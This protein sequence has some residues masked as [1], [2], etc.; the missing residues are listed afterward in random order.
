MTHGDLQSCKQWRSDT[1]RPHMDPVETFYLRFTERVT[2]LDRRQPYPLALAATFFQNLGAYLKDQLTADGY[3][4]PTAATNNTDQLAQLLE[5]KTR[6]IQA[7]H[8]LNLTIKLSNRG[9]RITSRTN[10]MVASVPPIGMVSDASVSSAASAAGPMRPPDVY[11]R[12]L[13]VFLSSAEEALRNAI[14]PRQQL[15]C[16][17]CQDL[18]PQDCSHRYAD[19]PRRDDPE[20]RRA[21]IPH[22]RRFRERWQQRR[23]TSAN[24]ATIDLQ[25]CVDKWEEK[26]FP[27]KKWAQHLV[28]LAHPDTCPTVRRAQYQALVHK[29]RHNRSRPRTRLQW[30]QQVP[31]VPQ[32]YPPV[33]QASPHMGQLQHPGPIQP[34]GPPSTLV[35]P[36]QPSDQTSVI[37]TNTT[38]QQG[39]GNIYSLI[40]YAFASTV[41]LRLPP[42]L[43]VSELL[44]HIDIPMG[45]NT[46]VFH[47]RTLFD[48]GA[49]LNMGRLPYHKSIHERFPDV[50]LAYTDFEKDGYDAL[51]I[52]GIEGGDF[53]PDVRACITYNTPFITLGQRVTITFGLSD[54][55][56][57]NSILGIATQTK[58]RMTFMPAEGVVTSPTLNATFKVFMEQTKSSDSLPLHVL[59]PGQTQAFV[60]SP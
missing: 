29:I 17:G 4:V 34:P 3:I 21:A 52:G 19:C 55:C 27:N 20:V 44:P 45:M 36:Q 49:G 58:A 28:T 40:V 48:T 10:A 51:R 6:A 8:R 38:Q 42:Q 26:G 11:Q 16:F 43:A 57:S 25:E 30:Q 9:G 56:V 31:Q 12:E 50:D 32:G 53:G 2:L 35:V 24:A 41:Q 5:L 14:E 54:T 22:L 47:L 33:A 23:L 60:S 18:Y 13:N 15:K 7:E 1:P 46:P 37:T 59:N 39:N